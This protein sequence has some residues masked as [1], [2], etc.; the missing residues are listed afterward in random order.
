M[1]CIQIC[2][3]FSNQT[4][5]TSIIFISVLVSSLIIIQ[6]QNMI[7]NFHVRVKTGKQRNIPLL[8]IIINSSIVTVS[9]KAHIAP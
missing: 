9:G 7:N 4:I 6:K 2:E 8:E 5:S 1:F 3:T